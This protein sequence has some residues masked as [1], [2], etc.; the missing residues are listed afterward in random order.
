[1]YALDD[2]HG[3]FKQSVIRWI[4]IAQV[5]AKERIRKAVEIDKVN[6]KVWHIHRVVLRLLFPGRTG[7]C[8]VDFCGGRK[9]EEPGQKPSEK[10]KNQQ[11][12]NPHMNRVRELNPGHIGG[13]RVLSPLRPLAPLG[14]HGMHT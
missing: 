4:D 13:R 10:G 2:Y 7:I 14:V 3:W 5:K 11:Q 8:S 9:T 1:M 12:L 6:K